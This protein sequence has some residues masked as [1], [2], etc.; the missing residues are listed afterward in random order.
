MSS[1][2]RVRMAPSPTGF[3][4]LGTLRTVL[5]D[6]FLA[7]Q[8]G[9]VFFLRIEDTDQEREVEGAVEGLIRTMNALGID[10]DEGPV[11]NADGTLSEKG[12]YGPYTQS[13]RL[14]L[15]K[16]Y[17]AD[18]VASGH[19][20]HC[21]CSSETL[22]Q[23]REEQTLAKQTPK[24]DR[25]CLKL[26]PAAI[27]QK[28]E[29]GESSV[30]RLLVPDNG[31]TIFTDVIRGVVSFDNAD[32]DDAV[33]LKSDGFP[34]YHL[35][36][37]VDDHLMKTTHVLRGEEWLSSTPKHLLLYTA[38]GWEA[39]VFAHV[40]LLLNADK[41]KLSKR[42]GDVS[43]ES[44]LNK[45]YLPKTLINFLGTL[46]FNPKSDQEIYSLAELVELFDLSKVNRGGAV[47]NLE[48][49]DWMNRHYLKEQSAEDFWEIAP[50]FVKK[51]DL[52]DPKV[53]RASLVERFRINRLDEL[54]GAIDQYFTTLDYQS[55]ILIWKKSNLDE[56]KQALSSAHEWLQQLEGGL[57]Q[58]VVSLEGEIKAKIAQ[59]GL[60]TGIVLWPLRVALSGK[61]QSA[62]PFELLYILGK[63][64]SLSRISAALDKLG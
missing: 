22:D 61:E 24:Y 19:A 58:E 17:A 45:G 11:L 15:Y 55:E 34:T 43:V 3:M 35:A 42:K 27:T 63:E 6:Y 23:M 30:I 2:T 50:R 38:F 37:V 13:K 52:S 57:W 14:D 20:Y 54:D 8:S 10:Y 49:L 29:S 44:H 51:H 48:K 53:K 9:G 12:D 28:I 64:E 7:R 60:G 31:K 21:F 40:P 59:S 36:V 25:R 18:L 4:H 41:T 5:F 32:V 1:Q 46:G 62:S 56:A 16:K 26:D 47:M 33:L 39:P